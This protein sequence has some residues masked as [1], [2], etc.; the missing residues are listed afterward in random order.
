MTKAADLAVE[1][2]CER[3]SLRL[4]LPLL[5]ETKDTVRTKTKG[6]V[7]RPPGVALEGGPTVLQ[8]PYFNSTLGIGPLLTYYSCP[9]ICYHT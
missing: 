3:L 1:W 7:I 8:E 9:K 4:N 5:R 2:R 6:A